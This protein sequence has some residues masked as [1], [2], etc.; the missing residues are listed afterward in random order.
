M[1][2][3]SG[4]AHTLFLKLEVL[5]SLENLGHVDLNLSGGISVG[6]NVEQIGGGN[7]VEARESGTLALHEVVEGLLAN[8]EVLL[9][10]VESSENPCLVAVSQSVLLCDGVSKD[11]LDLL[12]NTNELFGF[13]GQFLL[14]FLGVDEEV[15][16]ELP[17][18]LHFTG[19]ENDLSH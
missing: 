3:D 9:N 18:A 17:G 16:Q 8:A 2:A 6:Q 14:H 11:A 5:D 15:F 1:H 4:G 13:L 10:L 7:E 19:N 12:V